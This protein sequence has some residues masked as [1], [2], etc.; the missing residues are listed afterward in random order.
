MS[1]NIERATSEVSVE[2][3]AQGE[4][5]PAPKAN[6]AEVERLRAS[7]AALARDECRTRAEGFDD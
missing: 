1:V 3:E 6:R 7:K 5:A 2:P 4:P